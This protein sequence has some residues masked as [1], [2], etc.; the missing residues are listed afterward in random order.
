MKYDDPELLKY[1]DEAVKLERSSMTFYTAARNKASN[2]NMKSLLNAFLTVEVE[3][4]LT[5]TKVRDLVKKNETAKAIA[6]ANKFKATVP[7]NP[8]EDMVQLEKLS[9]YGSDIFSLFQSAKDL[10][11]KAE[12]FYRDAAKHV[13]H[14]ELK[15]FLLRFASDEKRHQAYL[16]KHREAVYNDG[17]W[18]GIGHVRL[19]T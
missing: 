7:V 14:P 6:A 13:R 17:Y 8:F 3:H 12:N 1:L 4:L 16:D 5:V 19:Q 10:E 18:L 9:S 15:R 2:F 11:V